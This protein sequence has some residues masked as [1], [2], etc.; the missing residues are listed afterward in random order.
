MACVEETQAPLG[1]NELPPEITLIPL[2]SDEKSAAE[3]AALNE[4]TPESGVPRNVSPTSAQVMKSVFFKEMVVKTKV[5]EE[6]SS[7]EGSDEDSGEESPCSCDNGDDSDGEELRQCAKE[8]V[9]STTENAEQDQNEDKEDVLDA[10]VKKLFNKKQDQAEAVDGE[11]TNS[12]SSEIELNYKGEE[13]DNSQDPTVDIVAQIAAND[14]QASQV[15][16]AQSQANAQE[17]QEAAEAVLPETDQQTQAATNQLMVYLLEEGQN[18]E[19]GTPAVT[20]TMELTV[21]TGMGE[22]EEAAQGTQEALARPLTMEE[23][24]MLILHKY[25]PGLDAVLK[26]DRWLTNNP[27]GYSLREALANAGFCATE[28][29]MQALQVNPCLYHLKKEDDWFGRNMLGKKGVNAVLARIGVVEG[30]STEYGPAY[31]HVQRFSGTYIFVRHSLDHGDFPGYLNK[32]KEKAEMLRG[33]FPH[34]S[35]PERSR[36]PRC[37]PIIQEPEIIFQYVHPALDEMVAIARKGKPSPLSPRVANSNTQQ[38]VPKKR[39]LQFKE[40]QEQESPTKRPRVAGNADG[41][42]NKIH[43]FTFPRL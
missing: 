35:N 23:K 40:N 26:D 28:L 34:L 13:T 30:H 33:E 10:I 1:S 27:E 19:N 12:V 11:E 36:T 22:V 8:C 21:P 3:M 9:H 14:F 42:V 43:Y 5:C 20:E 7:I 29:I 25:T 38:Q 32:L 2:G 37:T 39:C 16:V 24:Q 4:N 31:K 18:K 15:E 6:T 17:E 41:Q